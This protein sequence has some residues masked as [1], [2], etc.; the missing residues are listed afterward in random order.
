MNR[1]HGSGAWAVLAV[2][3]AVAASI[4]L[5]LVAHH[6]DGLA[7]LLVLIVGLVGTAIGLEFFN[8]PDDAAGRRRHS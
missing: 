8:H 1:T 3:S 2:L 5:L 7:S 6:T 4:G